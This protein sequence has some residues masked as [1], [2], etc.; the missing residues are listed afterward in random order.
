MTSKPTTQR[1]KYFSLVIRF[2]LTLALIYAVYRETGFFTAL[3]FFIVFAAFELGS[4]ALSLVKDALK[5]I[6]EFIQDHEAK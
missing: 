6:G 5:V 2:I 1:A 4:Y 3:S